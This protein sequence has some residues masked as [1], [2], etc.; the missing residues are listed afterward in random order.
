MHVQSFRY[1]RVTFNFGY[2]L[3]VQSGFEYILLDVN[4]GRWRG[5]CKRGR[6]ITRMPQGKQGILFSVFSILESAFQ[7]IN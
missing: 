7:G 5:A 4:L 6:D 1:I 2:K 3:A